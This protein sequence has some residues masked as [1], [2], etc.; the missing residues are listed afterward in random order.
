MSANFKDIVLEIKRFIQEDLEQYCGPACCQMIL[1]KYGCNMR[2]DDLYEIIDKN[3]TEPEK[4]HSDP[5]GISFILNNKLKTKVTFVIDD[6]SSAP[7]EQNKILSKIFYTLDSLKFPCAVL[8]NEGRHWVVIKGY[9][10]EQKSTGDKI[11]GLWLSDPYPSHPDKYY[12]AIEEFKNGM[13]KPSIYGEKWNKK[14]VI[15]SDGTLRP[16]YDIYEIRNLYTDIN[17]L[18]VYSSNRVL[19]DH[20]LQGLTGIALKNLELNGFENL[21]PLGEGGGSVNSYV[22]KVTCLDPKFS[23]YYL[24]IVDG[25]SNTS[26]KSDMIVALDSNTHLISAMSMG[27]TQYF[28]NDDKLKTFL[29]NS[30]PSLNFKIL[31]GIFW[32]PCASLRSRFDVARKIINY[33]DSKEYFVLPEG[34]IVTDLQEQKLKGG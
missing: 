25:T 28:L 14:F 24:L 10:I 33:S 29:M 21:S 27:S 16:L 12:C 8:I 26:F 17:P 31:P 32:K 18:S 34:R 23:D 5:D 22:F 1:N 7:E 13:L 30:D 9:R 4:W 2:Q 20:D 15:I 3:C 11:I 19:T 6:F